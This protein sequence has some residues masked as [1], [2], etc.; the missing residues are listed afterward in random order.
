MYWLAGAFVLI[1]IGAFYFRKILRD[2]REREANNKDLRSHIVNDSNYNIN[3][4]GIDGH[5]AEN[6]MT[7]EEAE[8]AIDGLKESETIPSREEFEDLRKNLNKP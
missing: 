8:A 6:N 3:H 4:E 2:Q 5:R 7:A 1:V